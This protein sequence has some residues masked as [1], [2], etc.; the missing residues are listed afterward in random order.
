MTPKRPLLFGL[1]LVSGILVAFTSAAAADEVAAY[2]RVLAEVCVTGVTPELSAQYQR[3][4]AAV[5]REASIVDVV[6][7]L[8]RVTGRTMTSKQLVRVTTTNP[9]GKTTDFWGPK[10]PDLAYAN[11][12][13]AR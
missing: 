7:H 1:V 2:Q 3:A 13:Q 4:V 11:C 5:D 9:H 6:P 10:P 12:T 8:A